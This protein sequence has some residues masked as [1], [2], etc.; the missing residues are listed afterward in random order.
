MSDGLKLKYKITKA[1]GR[2]ASGRYFVL[3]VDSKD[4]AHALACREALLTYANV[5]A[6]TIPDLS[7][8]LFDAIDANLSSGGDDWTVWDERI[9]CSPRPTPPDVSEVVAEMRERAD[10]WQDRGSYISAQYLIDW[11]DRLEG[12]ER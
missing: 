11:A 2:P 9:G 12:G 3:K 5:I 8:D 1:D 10:D 7:T 4:A 6:G